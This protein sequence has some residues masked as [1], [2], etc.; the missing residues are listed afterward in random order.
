MNPR[1]DAWGGDLAAARASSARSCARCARA[2]RRGSASAC[3]S[4]PRTSGSAKGLDLDETLQVARWLADDG[5]DFIH[6]SLWDATRADRRSAPTSIRSPLFRAAVPAD[7]ALIVAGA[8]WTHADAEAALAR[9]AD[10]VAL[11]RAAILNPDWPRTRSGVAAER[12]PVTRA[13]LLERRC[14]RCSRRT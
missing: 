12:P 14:R 9:G 13:E 10:V 2:C 3:G 5:V 7:V 11:G 1:T 8:I 4:R 6:A